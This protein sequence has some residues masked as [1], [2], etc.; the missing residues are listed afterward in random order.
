MKVDK[1]RYKKALAITFVVFFI[2][3]FQI[4]LL[5]SANYEEPLIEKETPKGTIVIKQDIIKD[6]IV[7]KETVKEVIESP[8]FLEELGNFKVGAFS[9]DKKSKENQTQKRI[10]SDWEGINIATDPEII[11]YGTKIWIPGVGIRQS[12]PSPQEMN[13]KEILVYFNNVEEKE[14][15][16]EKDLIVFEIKE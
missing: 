5:S 6:V 4:L 3:T 9:N 11:P 16:E 2:I 12:Q 13:G 10:M 15:F 1:K 14:E 7:K 8:I